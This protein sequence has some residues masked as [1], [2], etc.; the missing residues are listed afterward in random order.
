[1]LRIIVTQDLVAS[2][3]FAAKLVRLV[4]QVE[5]RSRSVRPV[6]RAGQ[7]GSGLAKPARP[8]VVPTVP[9]ETPNRRSLALRPAHSRGDLYVTSY[10]EGFS[11][12]VTSMT[13]P[14]AAM[15]HGS[16]SRLTII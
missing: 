10:T 7:S 16:E 3:G 12:F 8:E 11:H 2:L 6:V 9:G 13:A 1:M 4:S 15:P 14:V 5:R